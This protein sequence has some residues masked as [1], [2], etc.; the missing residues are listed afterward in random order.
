MYRLVCRRPPRPVVA[1]SLSLLALLS[2]GCN[3]RSARPDAEVAKIVERVERREARLVAQRA[4]LADADLDTTDLARAAALID[5]LAL[6]IT[7]DRPHDAAAANDPS[8]PL[9]AAAGWHY[10]APDGWTVSHVPLSMQW[11]KSLWERPSGRHFQSGD[12]DGEESTSIGPLEI[13][14]NERGRPQMFLSFLRMRIANMPVSFSGSL[15]HAKGLQ[16]RATVKM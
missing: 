14:K 16:L 2:T 8:A 3:L 13:Q 7:T 4:A 1:L 11:D 5:T 9:G 15:K 6:L 10:E 12:G